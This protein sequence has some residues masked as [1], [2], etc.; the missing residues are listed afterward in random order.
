M[1]HDK[2]SKWLKDELNY[3]NKSFFD[4]K[5]LIEEGRGTGLNVQGWRRKPSVINFLLT[6]TVR[7]VCM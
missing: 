7:R 2:I 4:N 6:M 1:S 3:G 5:Y